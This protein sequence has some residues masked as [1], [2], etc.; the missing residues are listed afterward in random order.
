M[1]NDPDLPGQMSRADWP[2]VRQ[3]LED[4]FATKTRD[5]WDEIMLGTDICYAPVLDFDEACTHPHNVERATFVEAGGVRQAA[6]APRFSRT[7]PELPGAA[8]V[9][10]A[11]TDTVLT[12]LGMSKDEVT[13]LRASGAV[14]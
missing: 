4:I 10:G 3:K 7:E 13:A 6:P 9:P 1:G 12:E 14:A 5:E 2:A 8:A 11:D